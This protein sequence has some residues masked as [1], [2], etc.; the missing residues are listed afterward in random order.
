MKANL[1][2][3]LEKH[4]KNYLKENK[5]E[6]LEVKEFENITG[7]GIVGRIKNQKLILGNSKNFKKI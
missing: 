3:Q 6:K 1:L 5:L 2:I 4:L 7:L